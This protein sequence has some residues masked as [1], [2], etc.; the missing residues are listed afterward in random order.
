MAIKFYFDQNVSKAVSDGLRLRGIDV[1]TAFEDDAHLL[2]DADLL[3]RATQLGR[4]LVTHDRHFAAEAS[5]RQQA[6]IFFAGIIYAR[7]WFIP[8]G[9]LVRDLELVAQVMEPEE[10]AN[11]IEYLPL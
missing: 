5:R 2:G 11:R 4:V 8:T 10:L 9:A 7:T 3:D 1:L 6:G